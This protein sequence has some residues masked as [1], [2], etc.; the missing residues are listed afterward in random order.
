MKKLET[1]LADQPDRRA[2]LQ[3]TLGQTYLALGLYREAIP[4][5]EK[6]RDYY[7]K[8]VGS[9]QTDTLGAMFNLANSYSGAGRK[10][11]ALKMR[12]EVLSLFRK[13]K[14]SRNRPLTRS[15]QCSTW[16]LPTPTPAARTRRSS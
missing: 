12:E 9:E 14:G 10:D 11:E 8:T 5:E 15:G 16:R 7:L 6:V 2:P 4:L 13:V 3:A 1:D